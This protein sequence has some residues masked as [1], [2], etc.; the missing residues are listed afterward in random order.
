MSY[1]FEMRDVCFS[2]NSVPVLEGIS[3]ELPEKEYLAI[4]GPNGGGKTTLAKLML[5]LME[6]DKGEVKV[7]GKPPLE[8]KTRIGYVPQYIDMGKGFPISVYDVVM[9]GR[10]GRMNRLK[11]PSEEDKAVVDGK[12]ELLG[13]QDC[14]KSKMG[15]LSGGQRQRVLI[16]RALAVEPDILIL[17]EPTSG[18]DSPMQV[19]LLDVLGEL[20]DTMTIVLVTHDFSV[21]S[22]NVTSV[23]CV[24]RTM[25]LHK[26]PEI[27][28]DMLDV[29]YGKGM[30]GQ[31]PVELIAHGI[32]HRVFPE[33]ENK[34]SDA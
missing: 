28:K 4:I 13:L 30:D 6:P 5:G 3:F 32:P 26:S 19:K 15:E 34:E 11:G 25:H 31:C 12:L 27:T 22:K 1:A 33:H 9:M 10:L 23:A 7:F 17:D 21:I 18:A 24:N 29:A 20:N 16:A 2:Y 8:F 14:R